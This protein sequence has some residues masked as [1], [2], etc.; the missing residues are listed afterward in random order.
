MRARLVFLSVGKKQKAC[1]PVPT[2]PRKL[3]NVRVHAQL[4]GY[5]RLFA[6][7]WAVAPLSMG[8]SRQE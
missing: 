8:F 3:C 4:L 2:H 1:Q 5:V 7:P 6:T